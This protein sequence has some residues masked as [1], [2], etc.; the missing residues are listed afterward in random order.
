MFVRYL[1]VTVWF[2]FDTWTPKANFG[3]RLHMHDM[4]SF[5]DIY[6]GMKLHEQIN[7]FYKREKSINGITPSC[8]DDSWKLHN[9]MTITTI[10]QKKIRPPTKASFLH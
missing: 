7:A 10:I 8:I 5:R 4:F 1:S 2:S 3:T 6:S 9:P